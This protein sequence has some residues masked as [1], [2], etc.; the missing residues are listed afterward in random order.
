MERINTSN[1]LN[2]NTKPWPRTTAYDLVQLGNY[3]WVMFTFTK[4]NGDLSYTI[5]LLTNC[6][7]MNFTLKLPNATGELPS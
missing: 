3:G 4:N 7:G 1:T 5:A 6:N 2:K